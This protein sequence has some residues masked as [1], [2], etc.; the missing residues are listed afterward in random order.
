MSTLEVFI[1]EYLA[2]NSAVFFLRQ[3]IVI[4]VIFV[5]GAILTDRFSGR[6]V[7][8]VR[9]VAAAFPV[10]LCAFCVTAYAML[11]IG[12]PYNALTVCLFVGI[13]AVAALV[14]GRRSFDKA[15]IKPMLIATAIMLVVAAIATS[16]LMPVSISNDTMY[17]FSRYP[18]AIVHFGKLRDQFDVFMTDTGLGAVCID[19]LPA[20]FGFGE[21]F[22]IRESFHISFIAYFA[23]CVYERARRRF[24]LRPALAAS[25]IVT[26]FLVISTPFV[27]LGHWAL[28][29]MYFMELFFIAAYEIYDRQDDKVATGPVLLLALAFLRIEGTLFVLWLILCVAL[30]R[31]IAR[32]LAVY[33]IVPMVLLF[34]GY[35]L[36][37]FVQF[38]VLDN[39]YT[40]LTPAKAALLVAA[41]SA[42]GIYLL[43]V[44]P[45]IRKRSEKY[46]RYAYLLALLAGNIAMLVRKPELYLVNLEVFGQNLFRQS[47]WG[48]FPYFVIAMTV[49]LVVEYA[50]F[51]KNKKG[52]I[53]RSDSFNISLTVGFILMVLAVSYGRGDSL[54]AYVGDS[55]NRVLLQV[56]PLTVMMYGELFM[57]LLRS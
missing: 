30:Y 6:D 24:E 11:V 43:F 33:V 20:L 39:I 40:F 52:R 49:L 7:K 3:C 17:Y 36:K 5:F 14:T 9:R 56:V 12:I 26:A 37:L 57:G 38:Y 28:A 47:G 15:D 18:D 19:T 10:G 13:E 35:C 1:T 34:G 45:L 48:M 22:G 21:S 27:I 55:G 4:A 29:N 8:P 51:Y 32:K 50:I 25:V 46:L 16:G 54:T 42:T 41:I 2:R 23:A 53:E 31:D 44:Y